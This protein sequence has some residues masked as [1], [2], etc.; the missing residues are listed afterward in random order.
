MGLRS[1]AKQTVS[2]DELCTL[3]L[4]V[5]GNI[6]SLIGSVVVKTAPTETKTL[7]RL[8]SIETESLLEFESKTK[9]H[10]YQ[11][12]ITTVGGLS[13]LLFIIKR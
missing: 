5:K 12:K 10:I 7:S 8:E 1:A 6:S 4:E 13:V 3:H 9:L 2:E 11:G